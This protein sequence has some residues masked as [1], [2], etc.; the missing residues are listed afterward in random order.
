MTAEAPQ[1]CRSPISNYIL[2]SLSLVRI[3]RDIQ[4]HVDG[5]REIMMN[6]RLLLFLSLLF[7]CCRKV[8]Y[9]VDVGYT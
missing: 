9:K 2:S 7:V 5:K 4:P 6:K 8:H 1:I 3:E